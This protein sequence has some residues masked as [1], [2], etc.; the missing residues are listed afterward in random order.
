M[1]CDRLVS[2]I[3]SLP[4][5]GL[6][7]HIPLICNLN[8][9]LKDVQ[10]NRTDKRER[11]IWSYDRADQHEVNKALEEADWAKVQNATD[12]DSAWDA[13]QLTFFGTIR[14]LIPS[15]TIRKISPKNS[16][17]DCVIK[18]AIKAKRSSFREYKRNPTPET[19]KLFC[20]HRN[21]VTHLIRKA[22]RR[23]AS[24]LHR[25]SRLSPSPESSQNFWKFVRRITGRSAQKPNPQ[26][27]L[28]PVTAQAAT[29]AG[30][31]AECFNSHFAR[32]TMLGVPDDET[33]NSCSLQFNTLSF[34]YLSTTPSDVYGI[35]S[36]LKSGKAP[37]IDHITPDLLRY[38]ANGIA[39]S[40]ACLFNR[41][42]E[43]SQFP[44]AWKEALVIPVYKKGCVTDPGNYR[45]IALLPIVSK[46]LERIVHNKLSSFLSPWLSKKQ[47]GFR[48][49]DG[50]V[51]QLVRL[52]QQWSEGIDRS[53]YIGALFF[54]L[55]KAFDK[56]WH[57]GLIAKLNAAGIRG[58]ALKWFGSFLENRNHVTVVNGRVSSPAKIHAGVPQGAILSP[59]LF[60]IYV[61]D[62]T[63][64]S[65][66]VCDINLFADDTLAF[67]SSPTAS[68]LQAK[69]QLAADVISCWFSEWHL[70]VNTTKTVS[71]V[72]RSQNMPPCTLSIRINDKPVEQRDTHRHLGVTFSSTLRWA[73]HIDCI[74]Y[75][76]S[77]KLGVLRRLRRTL[78]PA[79]LLDIYTTCI[80]PTL[81]Y[82]NLVW[83]GLSKSD[84]ARLE[85]CQ[86]S[87]AR[88]ITGIS[89]LADVSRD[90]L[91]AR[92][93]LC[94][95]EARR[96]AS[97]A[98][99]VKRLLT[100]RLPQHLRNVTNA[101]LSSPPNL[102]RSVRRASFILAL[103]KPKKE[104]LRRSPLYMSFCLWNKVMVD[105]RWSKKELPT[106]P[107]LTQHC[108]DTEWLLSR[109]QSAFQFYTTIL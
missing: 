47:S 43:L 97:L 59:L 15:K 68:A 35:L 50:T 55:K 106:R 69:L 25:A 93:G 64:A 109:Q 107:Q 13:W 72:I 29:T 88:I 82:A 22:E 76:A 27:L 90:L 102:R 36:K 108:L 79:V 87:A 91:L 37:G 48:K 92:A 80:R 38:C 11:T 77:R 39:C 61:N 8:V 101:W 86:R 94:T 100:D 32:Q 60:S 7:D 3:T 83:C 63:R 56:V 18:C 104:C 33:P 71:M 34:S 81:E 105:L 52:T 21:R 14:N 67:V 9:K 95:L 1:S 46:V 57:R 44:Q 62:I 19:R 65:A 45:P 89:P 96:N 66:S 2:E 30:E 40:L 42:F 78:T 51:P 70:T 73:E 54:D 53:H 49:A 103:P 24:T 31:Q 26:T 20:F 75:N 28:D 16:V 17:V 10:S 41:S 6:S 85:R 12:I 99:F 23:H 58:S 74:I 84:C 4:P 98:F 5:V